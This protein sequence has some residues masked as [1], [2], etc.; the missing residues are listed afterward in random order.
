MA[1]LESDLQWGA[2][3]GT[4]SIFQDAPDDFE[5][6]ELVEL[7]EDRVCW[8]AIVKAIGPEDAFSIS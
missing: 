8:R 7:A 6:E 1:Q 4:T 2:L 5:L 3:F